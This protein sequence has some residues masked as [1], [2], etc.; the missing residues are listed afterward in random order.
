MIVGFFFT[1]LDSL[2]WT[3]IAAEGCWLV[4]IMNDVADTPN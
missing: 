1:L 2:A 4:M 3:L